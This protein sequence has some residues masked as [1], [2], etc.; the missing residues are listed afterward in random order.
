[1]KRR[2][3]LNCVQPLRQYP[4]AHASETQTMVEM[5]VVTV[6]MSPA[7][8]PSAP[9]PPEL[10]MAPANPPPRKSG[11]GCLV[12][13][14]A[15]LALGVVV[16]LA[17]YAVFAPWAFYMGGHFHMFP[18]WTGWGRLHSKTAGDY[19]RGSRMGCSTRTTRNRSG[20]RVDSTSARSRPTR[21]AGYSTT[22]RI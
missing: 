21:R 15:A 7:R 8:V 4:V 2:N 9:C 5:I 17:I 10:P 6:N 3:P 18:Q 22:T 13:V 14:L 20:S 16:V 11:H 12:Q 1:M 19:L